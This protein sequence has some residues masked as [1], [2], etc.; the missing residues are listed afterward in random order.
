[1]RQIHRNMQGMSGGP[2]TGTLAER[3][4]RV[5][6]TNSTCRTQELRLAGDHQT[7]YP[8]E[9]E[10]EGSYSL[11]GSRTTFKNRPAWSVWRFHNCP[12]V[13]ERCSLVS[14]TKEKNL[15]RPD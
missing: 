6:A 11:M 10:A 14:S 9:E 4:H 13:P 7:T 15:I 1:V 3:E 2:S 12:A 8:P 5:A